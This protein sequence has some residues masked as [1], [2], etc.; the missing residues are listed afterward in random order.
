MKVEGTPLFLDSQ[1]ERYF[2]TLTQEKK[3]EITIFLKEVLKHE[4]LNTSDSETSLDQ[5]YKNWIKKETDPVWEFLFKSLNNY[6]NHKELVI[7]DLKRRSLQILK[8]LE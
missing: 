8:I 7:G 2:S 6:L 4:E 3:S 1:E 5:L